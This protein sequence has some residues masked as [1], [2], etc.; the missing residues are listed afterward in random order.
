M[1]IT[2][3]IEIE[4]ERVAGKFAS[5]DE[6][7]EAIVA[8]IEGAAPGSVDGLGADG[9]SEYEVAGWTVTT[10]ETRTRQ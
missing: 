9:E 3:E 6:I 10:T 5:R 2:V 8:E 1:R 4:V 7:E